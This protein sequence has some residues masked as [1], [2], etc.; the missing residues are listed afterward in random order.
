M[1]TSARSA[2][3]RCSS[4]E[5]LLSVGSSVSEAQLAALDVPTLVVGHGEDVVHPLA[6]ARHLASLIPSARFLEISPKARGKAQYEAAFRAG[7][8]DFIQEM[9]S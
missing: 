2:R 1:R 6:H 4:F 8:A 5:E 7:L 9:T 3:S